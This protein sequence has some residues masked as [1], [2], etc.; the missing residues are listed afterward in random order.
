[1]R[2]AKSAQA[3]PIPSGDLA[4]YLQQISQIPLLDKASERDLAKRLVDHGDLEAAQTL[5]LSHLR[6]VVHIARSYMGYGLPLADIVQEGN[7]GLMKAV[8][9]FDPERG[10]QLIS[11]AVHWIRA[12]IHEF[13]IKNWRIVK[14]ATTKQQRKLFFRLRSMKKSFDRFTSTEI[15]SIANELD[16]SPAAVK[17]MESRLWAHDCSLTPTADGTEGRSE[18]PAIEYLFASGKDPATLLEQSDSLLHE[19]TDLYAAMDTLDARSKDIISR[20]WLSEKKSTLKELSAQYQ[21]SGERIRQIEHQAVG[22]LRDHMV[23]KRNDK[24]AHAKLQ[25]RLMQQSAS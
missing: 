17:E 15:A 8:K 19:Q 7:I 1:M 4:V 25:Q 9:H 2:N 13:V 22:T 12:E 16:V 5:V 11:F 6:F 14:V 18:L 23:K 3:L 20:R 21:V 24:Q 10:V